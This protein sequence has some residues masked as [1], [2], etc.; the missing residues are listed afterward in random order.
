MHKNLH[1][2]RFCVIFCRKKPQREIKPHPGPPL[3]G[4]EK[5]RGKRR[6]GTACPTAS[7]VTRSPSRGDPRSAHSI[8]ARATDVLSR[9][10]A[11]R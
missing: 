10:A 6:E 9:G 3:K 1:L 11:G 5:R 7:K 8:G 4:R 2:T